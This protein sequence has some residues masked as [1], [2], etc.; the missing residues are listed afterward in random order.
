MKKLVAL[1]IL[2][3]CLAIAAGPTAETDTQNSTG[4]FEGSKISGTVKMEKMSLITSEFYNDYNPF[5]DGERDDL[6]NWYTAINLNFESGYIADVFGANVKGY[7]IQVMDTGDEWMFKKYFRQDENGDPEGF[8]ALKEYHLKQ[9]FDIGDTNVYLTQGVRV[10]R[11]FGVLDREDAAVESAYQGITAEVKSGGLGVN[12]AAV[13]GLLDSN[14]TEVKHIEGSDGSAIDYILTGDVSYQFGPSKLRYKAGYLEDYILTQGVNYDRF[15]DG[16]QL[17]VYGLMNSA[18]DTYK[19]MDASKRLFENNAY[20][21]G[22]ELNFFLPKTFVKLAY[23]YSKADRSGD[24]LGKFEQDLANGVRTNLTFAMG[25]ARHY[26]WDGQHMLGFLAF[27]DITDDF[28]LGFITRNSFGAKYQGHSL[29]S[30]EWAFLAFFDPSENV[31]ISV[32]AGKDY[33]FKQ[34]LSNMNPVIENGSVQKSL[35]DVFIA[36][37][38]YKF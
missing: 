20:H 23:T 17:Q 14:Q 15:F 19:D 12:F 18:L 10:L 2:F 9:K 36:G 6:S 28:K 30:R 3:P 21:F 16:G 25:D 11:D 26:S 13:N 27:R 4:F 32:I 24:S 34:Y 8:I 22:T 1:S 31:S 29:T 33:G 35:G 37:V 7:S 38:T 5:W